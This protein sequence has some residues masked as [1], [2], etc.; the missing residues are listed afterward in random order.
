[1]NIEYDVFKKS[2]PNYNKL[3]DYG[4]YMKDNSF[5]YETTF[6]D[7]FKAIISI[8]HSGE[9]SGKVIDTEI[10]EEYTN[11]RTDMNGKYVSNV[12]DNYIKLL[13]DIRDNCF[14][15]NNFIFDQSNRISKYI[16][17]KYK[18]T[19]EFLWEKH[20]GFG[21]FRNTKNNKW[22]GIIMNIDLSKLDSKSGEV[23]I[24]NLKLNPEK[25]KLLLEKSGFYKA[26]HMNKRDWISVLLNDS[27]SDGEIIS[28][29][30]ESYSIIDDPEKWIVPANPKYYDV[31][32]AFNDTDEI[33]WK[34]SSNINIGDI[35]Y[36]YVAA[37]Y[38]K[39]MYKC[40]ST[41]VNIPYNYVGK[42]VSI[43]YAMKIK[44][45]ERMDEKN[46][47]FE[48]L[49]SIGIKTIRGPRKISIDISNKIL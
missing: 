42:N 11:I 34:Q 19:S 41:E 10:D 1:M 21:V 28:L 31:I 45:L 15:V 39:I 20:P 18:V 32:N 49:N 26:Y 40:V 4:F 16:K 22:F 24:I 3:V 23:E 13:K 48:Y 35:V 17:D 5:L 25:V 14:D 38:S 33:I 46:Y 8:N 43:N 6:F 44:L 37:P 2:T 7:S 29:V 9:V 36:L 47:T 30:D 27:L 12:R